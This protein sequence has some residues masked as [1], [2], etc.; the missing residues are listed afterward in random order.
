MNAHASPLLNAALA[1][2]GAGLPVFPVALDKTPLHKGG[3]HAARTTRLPSA[4]CSALPVRLASASPWAAL[5]VW[6]LDIDR[7]KIDPT[8]GEVIPSGEETLAALVKRYG[9]LPTTIEQQT[10]GGG[11][12]SA[13]QVVGGAHPQP[14]A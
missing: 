12:Q 10:G 5:R 9:P 7:E 6:S 13:V 8:T 1:Y 2:A 3:F 4:L 14:C 11:R